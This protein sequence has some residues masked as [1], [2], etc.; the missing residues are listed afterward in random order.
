MFAPMKSSTVLFFATL[1]ASCAGC[2]AT[3]DPMAHWDVGTGPVAN[4]SGMAFV[5]GPSDGPS[6]AGATISV[7]EAPEITTTVAADGAFTLAVPSGAPISL[8]LQQPGFHA[9][10]TAA[11]ALDDGGLDQ[12]GFQVPTDGTFDLMATFVRVMPDEQLCQSAT[13][14][15]RKGTAPY[16]GAAL[17]EPGVVVA[18]D[19]PLPAEA[20]PIY[21]QY[22]SD[23]TIYPDPMLTETT[24][25]GGVLFVNVPP[26]EYTLTATKV[27][28]LF[29][30]AT[31]RCRAGVLV[32]AAPPRGLQEL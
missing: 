26:G 29:S 19:P 20:G 24:V 15:S 2:T 16:G 9:T 22:V 32:N 8:L 13:T 23:T 25:D 7:A 5:F 4:V 11:L 14:V 18:I 28:K 3:D 12:V 31:I 27:D 17:G 21:F 30:S 1:V 6:I 10:Q